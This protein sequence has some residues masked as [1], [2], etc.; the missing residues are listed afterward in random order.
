MNLIPVLATLFIVVFIASA[1]GWIVTALM[2]QA[3]WLIAC[4]AVLTACSGF[5][6][7]LFIPDADSPATGYI[8]LFVSVLVVLATTSI[9]RKITLKS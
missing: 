1:V 4:G 8:W 3:A 6:A 5:L 7:Y 9:A 2:N